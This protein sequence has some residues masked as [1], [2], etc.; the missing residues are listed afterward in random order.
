[1]KIYDLKNYVINPSRLQL[2]TKFRDEYVKLLRRCD[3]ILCAYEREY[4][5]I[6][7]KNE[8]IK[9]LSQDLSPNELVAIM[10]DFKNGDIPDTFKVS[11]EEEL[12]KAMFDGNESPLFNEEKVVEGKHL[13]LK[14][15][16][17][18]NVEYKVD[19]FVMDKI[20]AYKHFVACSILREEATNLYKK[21]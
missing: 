13:A 8:R 2:V 14:R 9:F 15:D 16:V 10:M 21:L 17:H 6:E 7:H 4:F 5:S 20:E 1:M 11:V 19:G 18:G 12:K 3:Y